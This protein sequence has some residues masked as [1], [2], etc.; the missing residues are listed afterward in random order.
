MDPALWLPSLLGFAVLA[1]LVSFAFILCFGRWLGSNGALISVGAIL[2]SLVLSL[3]S[4]GIWVAHH[5]M[6]SEGHGDVHTD[7]HHALQSHQ[8]HQALQI[9]PVA[10]IQGGGVIPMPVE[11]DPHASAA[12]AAPVQHGTDPVSYTKEYWQ[13]GQFGSLRLTIDCYIDS[14][15]VTMFCMVTLIASCI[16]FYAMGYMHDELHTVTDRE[17]VLSNGEVLTRPGRYPRFFQFLSLFCFSMLGLV[18]AGNIAMVFV[19][20]ELVGICSYFLIGFYIERKSASTAANKAFIVN[21]VGDFGMII[22]LMAIWSSVGTFAFGDVKNADGS[23]ERLGLFSTVRP[24]ENGR[25]LQ[26][27]E[28]MVRLSARENIAALVKSMG[29]WASR[30]EIETAIAAKIPEWRSGNNETGTKYGYWLLVVAGVGIFCGCVGKS[31]QFPLHV[32]LPDA[33]EGPTPVSALVHSATMVAAGV[34]LVGRF[35]PVFAPEVLLII[36]V[37]GCITLFMAATIAI[38]ATDIKRVLA[39]STVSQ[40]GYMMLGLGVGGWL[41]GLLHLIT[42]AFFKSLLFLCSGSVIHAVHTNDMREMGGLRKKMPITAYTMLIGCLAIAGMHIFVVGFSGHYSKDA[43]LEQAW[44][45]MQHNNSFLA[46]ALFWTAAGGA[47]ITAFYMFRMWYLTFAGTPRNMER[48]EHAHESPKL[49]YVPLIILSVFAT[50]VAWKGLDALVGASIALAISL[51]LIIR[52]PPSTNASGAGQDRHVASSAVASY[53]PATPSD[54]H[55]S[56]ARQQDHAHSQTAHDHDGTPHAGTP[57]DDA[58]HGHDTLPRNLVYIP[59]A[60][61]MAALLIALIW[62]ISP[63]AGSMVL[64]N[65]LE[66]ARPAGVGEGTAAALVSMNW[67]AEHL[68]HLDAVRIPV[69]LL[70]TATALGGIAFATVMYGLGLL[71]PD[72]VRRQFH[73]VYRFLVNKWWFDELYDFLLVRPVH[74]AASLIASIDKRWIDGFV[75]GLAA[76]TKRIAVIWD[77]IADRTVIDGIVNLVASWTYSIGLTAREVQTGKIR[78]YVMFIV[79]GAIAIFVIISFF[80]NSSLAG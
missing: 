5:P 30:K 72:E 33:M 1:P 14:L 10:F 57:H 60:C 19:F 49:M 6:H 74:V 68:S 3:L 2:A 8:A 46:S 69:T 67:P 16:H 50:A 4:L 11:P 24:K 38:T 51:W 41:G 17:V 25:Q 58:I 76:I 15:T 66:A 13:L 44:S 21:R 26:T 40:L 39:Y 52:Y 70:A 56:G 9:R 80:W 62:Q 36:A 48:Y 23:V 53:G 77:A 75:H 28:G 31:A 12:H 20:W 43:I 59:F 34:Y 78:Q 54:S 37:I 42:H 27:P 79:V 71:N 32:W 45:F 47:G 22:G 61:S 35:Y 64:E 63:L 18:L 7:D 29:P 55:T 65:L 73:L